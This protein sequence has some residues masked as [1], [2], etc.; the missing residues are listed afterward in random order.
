MRVANARLKAISQI[1]IDEDTAC[2]VVEMYYETIKELL[3]ALLLTKGFRSD[4]HECL[5]AFLKHTYPSLDHEV[6]TI[7][8]L[9]RLRNRINYEGAFVNPSYLAMN[10]PEIQHIIALLQ[11]MVGPRERQN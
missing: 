7:H 8:Q 9:K 1:N 6:R 2:I 10:G 5:I 4:N 11:E 3:T